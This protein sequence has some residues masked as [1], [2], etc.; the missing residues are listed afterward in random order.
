MLSKEIK[1]EFGSVYIHQNILI[2]ELHEGILFDLDSNQKLL[3]LAADIFK[4]ASYGYISHRVNSYAVDP[5]VY[6]KSANTHNLK[7]IAVVSENEM[8]RRN[9]EEVEKKFYKGSNSFEVFSSLEEAIAWIS[10]KI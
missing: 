9:A 4:G 3:D 6:I 5:M 1:L 8:S 10:T 7:A 2:A